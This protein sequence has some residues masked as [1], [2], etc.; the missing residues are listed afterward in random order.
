MH[1]TR[2]WGP[3]KTLDKRA[4]IYEPQKSTIDIKKTITHHQQKHK[5]QA[6]EFNGSAELT[7]KQ[8]M[9]E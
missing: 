1:N 4:R 9:R 8:K 2:T 6:K 3:L 5:I 7:V